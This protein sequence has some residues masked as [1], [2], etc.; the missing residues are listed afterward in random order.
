MHRNQSSVD[1]AVN[2]QR[3]REIDH[4]GQFINE[5]VKLKDGDL[6]IEDQ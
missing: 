3:R 6:K 2:E 5:D 4:I 1:V